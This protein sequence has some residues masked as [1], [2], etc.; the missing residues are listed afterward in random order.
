[1]PSKGFSIIELIIYFV[2]ILVIAI[3]VFSSVSG[4]RERAY[5][6][7]AKKDLKTIYEA[8]GLYLIKYGEFPTDVNRD[9]PSGLEEFFSPGYWPKA[10]WPG[11]VF[12]WDNWDDPD[13][14][15]QKIYQ[16]SIRFC[17]IGQPSQCRFPKEPWA[18]NF[19]VN[20]SV[21]WCISGVCRAHGSRP[22]NHPG[23]C[24]NCE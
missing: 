20:S 9:L 4:V 24:I 15:G 8:L 14:P 22:I 16:I 12:D 13:N 23:Y 3:F 1:M 10:A 7:V 17:P 6:T 5:F 21:Y 19:D 2:I 11:S 18:A